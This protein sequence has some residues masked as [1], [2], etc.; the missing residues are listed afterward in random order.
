M[1]SNSNPV[2]SGAGG[3]GD[4]GYD[5]Q[6]RRIAR[7][8]LLAILLL[9]LTGTLAELLL[10]RHTG[11]TRELIPLVLT[12]LTLPALAW[13]MASGDRVSH[14]LLQL[15]MS[16][17]VIA[18]VLGAWFHFTANVGYEQES[19]PGLALVDVYKLA[20]AGSTPTLAP[21]VFIQMGLVGFLYLYMQSHINRDAL[22][23]PKDQES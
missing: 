15:L 18:G 12:A 9:G 13:N 20:I 1:P 17:F 6:V 11:G 3:R 5:G 21:G 10:L 7:A 4:S 19:N 14:R 23:A 8:A 22:R 16:G 2:K